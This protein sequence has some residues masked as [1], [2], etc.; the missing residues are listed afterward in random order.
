MQITITLDEALQR[1]STGLRQKM[2]HSVELLRKAEKIARVYDPDDG[3][4]LAFSGGKDSQ[5][6]IHIAQLAGVSY[7]AH[8]SPTSVDPPAVIKFIRTEYPEVQFERLKESIY[9]DA[10]RRGILPTQKVRWCC[11]DFKEHA[12][13]GKVTL[14]GIRKAESTRRAKR[15]EVEFSGKKF[16]GDFEQFQDWRA[17]KLGLAKVANRGGQDDVP[18]PDLAHPEDIDRETISGCIT[19]K[20]S[21]LVSPIIYWTEKDV[22]E[23]LNQVVS[24]PHCHLYDEGWHRLGCICC[25]MSSHKQK[26]KELALYP[27]VKRNWIRAIMAIRRGG[28]FRDEYIWWNMPAADFRQGGATATARTSGQPL[29]PARPSMGSSH[30]DG[31]YISDPDPSRWTG[32][33][34]LQI[35]STRPTLFRLSFARRRDG[36]QRTRNRRKHLRL[37]DQRQGLQALVCREVPRWTHR[38]W[39]R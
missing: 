36:G 17:K 21:L 32:G 37:V 8:F 20:D 30:G 7:K 29:L 10:I 15:N 1:A 3:F 24:V 28:V 19:G 16:S 27:H 11:A 34:G 33:S 4:Y 18:H 6:L 31:A 23:F 2:L 22:W 25:P 39:R 14:I 35:T 9:T 13:A 26:L 12:G 5:A 38:L